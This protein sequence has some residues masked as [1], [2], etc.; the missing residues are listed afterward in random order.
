M[1]TIKWPSSAI[2]WSHCPVWNQ[3]W[4]LAH[5]GSYI[6]FTELHVQVD[7]IM[8]P[9]QLVID[10]YALKIFTYLR[11][12][13]SQEFWV[14]YFFIF[15]RFKLKL[16]LH[17]LNK[18]N[19]KSIKCMLIFLI[20]FLPL[21]PQYLYLIPNLDHLVDGLVN[22]PPNVQH[23]VPSYLTACRIFKDTLHNTLNEREARLFYRPSNSIYPFPK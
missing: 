13:K 8:K 12:Q 18:V 4:Y 22:S 14:P 10:S 2:R 7:L 5:S 1:L 3:G 15:M 16:E 21:C 19:G 20:Y 17:G 9:N 6:N 11:T 23:C